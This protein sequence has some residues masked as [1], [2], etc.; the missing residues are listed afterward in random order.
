MKELEGALSAT[1][2]KRY[3]LQD[4][5]GTMEK[6]LQSTKAHVNQM[7]DL[8]TRYAPT[9]MPNN[10][11]FNSLLK[12]LDKRRRSMSQHYVPEKLYHEDLYDNNHELSA[13]L[14]SRNTNSSKALRELKDRDVIKTKRTLSSF[15]SNLNFENTDK[16]ISHGSANFVTSTTLIHSLSRK[17]FPESHDHKMSQN[18]FDD[19]CLNSHDCMQ[20]AKEFNIDSLLQN[21]YSSEMRTPFMMNNI[22]DYF[23]TK[24][25]ELAWRKPNLEIRNDRAVTQNMIAQS[26]KEIRRNIDES[27]KMIEEHHL[28]RK[29]KH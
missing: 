1:N 4:T 29:R 23:L 10:D 3:K 28:E 16:S 2:E 5:I 17:L 27:L 19:L 12:E 13:V 22:K 14:K 20:N 9:G 8:Q 25:N 11:Q 24:H 7:A 6:E 21:N 26:C 15:V 18:N